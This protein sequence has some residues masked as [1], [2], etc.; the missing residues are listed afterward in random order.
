VSTT[1]PAADVFRAVADPTRRAL[2]DL[3]AVRDSNV[4][5]LVAGVGLSYSAVSQHLAILREAGLV[6]SSARG[7]ERVY[8]LTPEPLREVHRW[9][10]RYEHFWQS[11]LHR[12]R[13]VLAERKR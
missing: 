2:L 6:R 12:L 13:H 9:T 11:R 8:R 1:Q 4:A 5:D 3:M 7:R 10:S